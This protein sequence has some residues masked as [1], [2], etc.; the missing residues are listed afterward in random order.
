MQKIM[1]LPIGVTLIVLLEV[2]YLI[3]LNI[4]YGGV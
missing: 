2:A 1:L 4:K 3:T